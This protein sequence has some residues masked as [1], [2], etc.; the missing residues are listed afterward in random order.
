PARGRRNLREQGPTV[1]GT[2]GHRE[3]CVPRHPARAIVSIPF[4]LCQGGKDAL[5]KHKRHEGR[6]GSGRRRGTASGGLRA[7]AW[8][9]A[10]W[11]PLL[12]SAVEGS[13][14]CFRLSRGGRGCVWP[15]GPW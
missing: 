3:R 5:T 13:V 8:A 10:G 4:V 12:R 7:S 15:L 11:V 1:A 2:Y 6:F 14:A 9:V